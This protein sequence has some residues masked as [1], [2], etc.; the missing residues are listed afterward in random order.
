[1]PRVSLPRY[2]IE[3]EQDGCG[4]LAGVVIIIVLVVLFFSLY[5]SGPR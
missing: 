3:Y 2:E 1:M 5:A 4:C